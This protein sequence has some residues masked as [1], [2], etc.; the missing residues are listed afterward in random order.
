M[1]VSSEKQD[2]SDSTNL[3]QELPFSFCSDDTDRLVPFVYHDPRMLKMLVARRMVTDI[4]PSVYRYGAS[5]REEPPSLILTPEEIPHY[6]HMP[7]GPSA[8]A[9][10]T[11]KPAAHFP[12]AGTLKAQELTQ[13]RNEQ[14]KTTENSDD[15]KTDS[16]QASSGVVIA[17]LNRIPVLEEALDEEDEAPRLSQLISSSVRTFELVYDCEGTH[18]DGKPLKSK[19]PLTSL[20]L[21][22]SGRKAKYDLGEVY[23]PKLESIYGK[24]DYQILQDNRPS[25]LLDELPKTV[26]S[27]HNVEL[28]ARP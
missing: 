26:A 23:I 22:S 4:S 20:L 21:S 19:K 15:G 8:R 28:S 13:T 25:F 17:A 7:T 14:E 18:E 27:K 1:W 11:I 9:L 3:V 2:P 10:T 5:S 16:L 12:T 24:L 6:I